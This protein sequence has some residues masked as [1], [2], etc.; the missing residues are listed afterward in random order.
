MAR[1]KKCSIERHKIA[2]NAACFS[3]ISRKQRVIENKEKF[4]MIWVEEIARSVF[5]PLKSMCNH[6]TIGSS[7]A[8]RLIKES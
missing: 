5:E 8:Y 1:L 7:N 6:I 2:K 3:V 4:D